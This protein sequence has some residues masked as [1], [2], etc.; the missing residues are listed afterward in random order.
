MLSYLLVEEDGDRTG[1]CEL[2][3]LDASTETEALNALQQGKID[4]GADEAGLRKKGYVKLMSYV[5]SGAARSV[6]PE[7]HAP[8]FAVE[9][10]Q[11]SRRGDTFKTATNK[12]VR[13]M[14]NRRVEGLDG[15]GRGFAMTYAV[16]NIAAALD[17]VSQICDAGSRVIFE[18]DGGRIETPGGRSVPLERIGNTYFRAMWVKPMPGQSFTRQGQKAL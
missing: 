7:T 5:D 6:C 3:Y 17:S 2:G 10:T 13:N 8:Q 16:A 11:A 14:G 12:K 18:R 4:D 1:E 15:A 9:E